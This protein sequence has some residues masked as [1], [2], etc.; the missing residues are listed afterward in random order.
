MITFVFSMWIFY[1]FCLVVSSG[2]WVQVRMAIESSVEDWK[3]FLCWANLLVCFWQCFS[4]NQLCFI[5]D[6]P[7]RASQP[8]SPTHDALRQRTQWPPF[9]PPKSAFLCELFLRDEVYQPSS[10][11]SAPATTNPCN[12]IK[13]QPGSGGHRLG[14]GHGPHRGRGKWRRRRGGAWSWKTAPFSGGKCTRGHGSK[15]TSSFSGCITKKLVEAV[16]GA[17]GDPEEDG[18]SGRRRSG[19]VWTVCAAER[20]P[21]RHAAASSSPVG[22]DSPAIRERG[23]CGCRDELINAI[24]HSHCAT[25]RLFTWL[26]KNLRMKPQNYHRVFVLYIVFVVF[27]RNFT[28]TVFVQR[29]LYA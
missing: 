7:T 22:E 26:T 18:Q 28:I 12:V 15:Q 1:S 19:S 3:D 27:E 13:T 24:N 20:W 8:K 5:T 11:D 16:A 14:D 17:V 10:S 23:S 29:F 9:G 6:F 21:R 4:M 25:T 2:R